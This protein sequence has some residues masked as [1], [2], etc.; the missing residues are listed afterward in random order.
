M[1]ACSH[2][3]FWSEQPGSPGAVRVAT[4]P[5]EAV[6]RREPDRCGFFQSFCS[7]PKLSWQVLYPLTLP[8]A[9][10]QGRQCLVPC[11]KN[12]TTGLH[13]D[14]LVISR[15]LTWRNMQQIM[16][17]WQSHRSTSYSLNLWA[18]DRAD[19]AVCLCR[20]LPQQFGHKPISTGLGGLGTCSILPLAWA[21]TLT[22]ISLTQLSRTRHLSPFSRPSACHMCHILH[23]CQSEAL[24]QEREKCKERILGAGWGRIQTDQQSSMFRKI[25]QNLTEISLILK[26]NKSQLAR[27]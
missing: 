13:C 24:A 6:R 8:Q 17:V 16:M 22:Q 14:P 4:V 20:G 10:T 21:W 27:G 18:R 1:A 3:L 26:I 2:A 11:S 9:I 7:P 5:Q 15:T 12:I 19:A 23:V 25:A